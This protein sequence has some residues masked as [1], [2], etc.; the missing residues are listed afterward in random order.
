MLIVEN[1]N[2]Q[3]LLGLPKI[4][5]VNKL[6]NVMVG[7]RWQLVIYQQLNILMPN[8]LIS[9]R[10]WT[11]VTFMNLLK[12]AVWHHSS[13]LKLL[14]DLS[15]KWNWR[16]DNFFALD[17]LITALCLPQ[18]MPSAY[19]QLLNL[20]VCSYIILTVENVVTSY[21]H[22]CQRVQMLSYSVSG[23]RLLFPCFNSAW[24]LK[25]WWVCVKS[26]GTY[27]V[28]ENFSIRMEVHFRLWN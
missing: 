1:S 18:L 13:K 25:L 5:N 8:R 20:F 7:E 27:G 28:L 14:N 23:N 16:I 26:A 17:L 15:C 10:N 9:T 21:L 6:V 4:G 2:C 12:N 19:L 11:Y 22:L 3:T 24:I